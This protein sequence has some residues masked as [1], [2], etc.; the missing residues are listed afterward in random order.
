MHDKLIRINDR[1]TIQDRFVN[2]RRLIQTAGAGFGGLALQHLL[3]Q[4]G[5]LRAAAPGNPLAARPA[6]FAA[7]AKSVIFIFAYGGP[8]HVDMLD[9]KPA[10]E[11][12]HGKS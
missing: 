7:R 10:L 6:H 8:S 1:P 11:K 3:G 12:W 9:Y 5:S 4:E 2:R